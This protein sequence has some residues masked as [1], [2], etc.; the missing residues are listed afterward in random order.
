MN[1]VE[2]LEKME[3][4]RKQEREAVINAELQK[5]LALYTYDEALERMFFLLGGSGKVEDISMQMPQRA[6]SVAIHG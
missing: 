1:F 2:Y 4:R 5:E 6:E 3:I